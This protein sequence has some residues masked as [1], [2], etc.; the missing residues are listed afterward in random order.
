MTSCAAAFDNVSVNQSPVLAPISNQTILSGRTLLVTNSAGDADVPAQTLA[1]SL[2]SAPT[3]A[4]INTNSGVFTWRPTIAQAPSTQT[5]AVVVSDNGLPILNATQNFT[6][7]VTSPAIPTLNPALMTNGHFGFLIN[8]D[9]GPDYTILTSTNLVSWLPMVTN[10]PVLPYFWID[11]NS[12]SSPLR[13]Y[14]TL[15]GP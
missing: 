7:T 5:V 1:Y 14:R 6:I 3:A 15:L 4:S 2:L 12:I 8:G 10:T 9:T 11:T 13:F